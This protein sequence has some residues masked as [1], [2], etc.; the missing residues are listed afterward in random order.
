MVIFGETG[1][2][3]SGSGLP[4]AEPIVCKLKYLATRYPMS[5]EERVLKKGSVMFASVLGTS[6]CPFLHVQ[7]YSSS[8]I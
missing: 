4:S 2:S 8:T 5:I 6:I 7:H 1:E 3:D